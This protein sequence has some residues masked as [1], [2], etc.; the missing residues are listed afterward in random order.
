M[1]TH[2]YVDAIF[3]NYL[4]PQITKP[5]KITPTTTTV[6]DSIYRNDILSENNQL[7]GILY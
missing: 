2:D 7:Q 6:I 5:T 3:S 4:I 1:E